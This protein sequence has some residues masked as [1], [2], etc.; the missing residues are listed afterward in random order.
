MITAIKANHPNLTNQKMLY[1]EIRPAHD[2]AEFV[3]DDKAGLKEL[4]EALTS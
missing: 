2:R 1:V 3:T 4:L